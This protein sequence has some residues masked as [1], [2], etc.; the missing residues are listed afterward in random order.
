MLF[1]LGYKYVTRMWIQMLEMAV[2][3]NIYTL[4]IEILNVYWDNCYRTRV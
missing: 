1:E 2:S 4:S 3:K